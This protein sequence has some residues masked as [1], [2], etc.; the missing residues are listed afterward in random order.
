MKSENFSFRRHCGVTSLILFLVAIVCL[1]VTPLVFAIE[2]PKYELLDKD[3]D[4]EIRHYSSVIQATTVMNSSSDSSQ[5]F[6]TLAG[7]IFGDNENQES[8]SMT[9][10]VQE[11]L[12]V[13][14]PVMAFTM[15]RRF[16]Q[17]TLP[18]PLNENVEIE[19]VPERTVAVIR[20]SGWA[21][22]RKVDRMKNR[23]EEFLK[24]K[25]LIGR[26]DWLLNQYNPPWTLPFMRRNEVWVELTQESYRH[27]SK[28]HSHSED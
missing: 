3:G 16:T 19:V 15:P 21:S 27:W 24:Q 6:K 17:D 2:E 23:L 28:L 18:S 13:S 8:I 14:E 12:Y 26:G 25:N 22:D 9:A 7:F 1:L 5:G 11:S 4:F 10:P 20:F